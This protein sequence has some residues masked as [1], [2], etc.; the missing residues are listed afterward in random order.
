MIVK[1]NPQLKI[2]SQFCPHFRSGR[3][4]SLYTIRAGVILERGQKTGTFIYQLVSIGSMNTQINV[5]LS[6]KMLVSAQTYAKRHG[7][8]TIQELIKETMREKLF[9]EPIISKE[10]LVLVKKLV[11]VSEKKNLYGTEEELFQKLKSR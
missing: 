4:T 10:E 6:E 8:G 1:T 5:R 9:E 3:L 2:A 11:E 7:F